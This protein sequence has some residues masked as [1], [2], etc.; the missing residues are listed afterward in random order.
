MQSTRITLKD[1]A[2]ACGYTVNTVSR[3]L[4]DD[5]RLPDSTRSKIRQ[6]A[7][8]MGYIRN[9]LAST[10]RSGRSH[11]V[12]VIVNDLH[13]LHFC[14]MLSKM[15]QSLRS[16]G[17]S[18][19]VLCMQLNESLG[20]QMIHTAISQ[21]VDGILY[22]PYHNNRDH[23]EYMEKNRVPF[24]LLDRWIQNVVTDN[25]RCDD[26]Q[27]GRLAG[28]H[29]A[30]LGHRRFLFLSGVNQSSSQID[31]LAGFM[32]A[33]AGFGLGEGD[34]RIVPGDAVERALE[35]MEIDRL[36]Y[37][38]DYTAIVCFRDEIAYPAIR[39]LEER[40]YAVPGD[41]SV[42]SFDHLCGEMLY[43]PKVTSIYAAQED[44]ATRG[45]QLLLERIAHPADPA[46]VVIL[47][48]RVFDEGTT[49]MP[50][51]GSGALRRLP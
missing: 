11:I 44:V 8:D 15:D 18:M 27:G 9:S 10:L 39:A 6:T 26:R 19:M 12:A 25:V 21:S 46:Q 43:L 33:I 38:K 47:P 17:Y 36:L 34:V 50:P 14:N 16:A 48:V 13:N 7:R 2:E 37:P 40:G 22:F 23:I 4:R 28:E 35:T 5:A 49:A 20:E 42:I 24:V 45:V 1:I 29:L 41:V 31:R 51:A 30:R 32:E 3:A